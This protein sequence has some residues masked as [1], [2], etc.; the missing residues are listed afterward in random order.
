MF[1]TFV[2]YSPMVFLN[3]VSCISE[4]KIKFMFPDGSLVDFRNLD[5]S[6]TLKITEIITQCYDSGLN[7]RNSNYLETLR[8]I[9][10]AH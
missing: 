8:K 10:L 1:N 6:F 2:K 4:L 9:N 5:H 3:P 7:S